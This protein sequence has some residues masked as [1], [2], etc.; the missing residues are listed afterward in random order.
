MSVPLLEARA[1]DVRIAGKT[2]CAQLDLCLAAGD[3][4][5]VLGANGV[6]KTTL[7][8]TL[9]G[10]RAPAA[11]EVLL[12]GERLTMLSRR[13]IARRL[14]VLMQQYE[15]AFPTSVLEAALIGRHPH[16][17]FW[18]WESHADVAVARK[19]LRQVA[20][21]GL[22]QR[23]QH[24]LSGGE[25]RRLTVATLL[26]QDPAVFLLDEPTNHLD[27]RYQI[28]LLKLFQ[29]LAREHGRGVI[30]SLHDINLATRFCDSALLLFGEGEAVFGRIDS[31]LTTASL[32]RLYATPVRN[33]QTE[34][35]PLF[36]PG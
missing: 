1:L 4:I 11:G 9:A 29:K 18:R 7:L 28:H 34:A 30:M 24:T 5:A 6:G 14:G 36:L 26:A 19:A 10:L 31:V 16:I 20:L 17:D 8:N 25:L 22:E 15:E 32:S 3:C 27:L 13:E 21:D 12:Q 33:L 35:G 2:V 23:P